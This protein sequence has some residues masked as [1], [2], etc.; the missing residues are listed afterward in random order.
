MSPGGTLPPRLAAV[1]LPVGLLGFGVAVAAAVSF[2][3]APRDLA[4]LAGIAGL[5]A[6]SIAGRALPGPARRD[7]HGRRL[8]RLRLLHGRD[9]ALRLAGRRRRRHGR[10]DHAPVRASPADPRHLQRGRDVDRRRGRGRRDRARARRRRRAGLRASARR[11]GRPLRG[12]PAADQ[13]RRQRQLAETDRAGLVRTSITISLGDAVCVDG[14]CS[15]DARDPL[16]AVAVPLGRARRSAAPRSLSTSARRF[17]E[18]RA[19]PARAG[20]TR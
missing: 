7:R 17:R 8:A 19:I 20:P 14:L 2:A 11:G 13:P 9:R 18:L 1:V 5:L 16:A 10:A 3:V 4:T 15:L 6:A 12:Q